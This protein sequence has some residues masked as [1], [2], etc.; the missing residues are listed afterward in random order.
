ML[1]PLLSLPVVLVRGEIDRDTRTYQY[2]VQH[3]GEDLAENHTLREKLRR[4]FMLSIPEFGE[5]DEPEAYFRSIEDAVKNKRRWKVRRQI[6]LGM[7]SFGKLAIW[8][9]L[10]G[11]KNPALTEHQ[12]IRSV[13]SG[14]TGG[15]SGDGGLHA[16]DYKID[17]LPEG[18]KPLI[19]DADSSQHSAIIDVL[20]GKNLVINGPPGTGK[21]QT[22]TNIV[23]AAL[24]SGKK[25]LFVSEKTAALEVVHRRLEE[26]GLGRFCLPLHSNKARK[27]ASA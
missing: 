2:T 21:S 18:S 5:E 6:T 25:V 4:D 24:S 3:N 20:A 8:A 17:A 23:A 16:E 19:Y 1:A 26:I 7:L 14:G 15:S 11:K 13:F 22:I 9:D 27:A 10:D 12:L